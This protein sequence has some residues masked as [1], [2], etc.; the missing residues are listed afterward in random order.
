MTD[1]KADAIRPPERFPDPRLPPDR[2]AL[3]GAR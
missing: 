2:L 1:I 3:P